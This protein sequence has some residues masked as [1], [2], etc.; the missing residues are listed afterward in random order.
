MKKNNTYYPS[1]GDFFP[2]DFLNKKLLL[3]QIIGLIEIDIGIEVKQIIFN[4]SNVNNNDAV[5][6]DASLRV[7]ASKSEDWTYCGKNT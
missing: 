1:F 7:I 6:L 5:K 3:S 2:N 4:D